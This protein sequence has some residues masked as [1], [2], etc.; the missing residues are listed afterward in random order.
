MH[1]VDR[2]ADLEEEWKCLYQVSLI[3]IFGIG[4]AAARLD[5]ALELDS[6]GSELPF[7][8]KFEKRGRS[9]V[10]LGVPFLN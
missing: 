2:G 9:S 7:S 8:L 5:N 3:L 1:A 4:N 10:K 6:N